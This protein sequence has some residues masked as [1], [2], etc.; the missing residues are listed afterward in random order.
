MNRAV[1]VNLSVGRGPRVRGFAVR[2][3]VRAAGDAST[4]WLPAFDPAASTGPAGLA[5]QRT[6]ATDDNS[7]MPKV[8]RFAWAV[9]A[10]N[11]AV[12]LWGAY[13]PGDGLGRGLWRPL[14]ALQRR[15]R[16]ARGGCGDLDRVLTPRDQRPGAAGGRRAP[17]RH[18]PHLPRRASGA[19]RRGDVRRADSQRG[20]DRRRAGAVPAGGRQRDDGPG[21]V[22]RGASAEHVPAARRADVD[23]LVA[24]RRLAVCDQA[25]GHGPRDHRVRGA[26]RG[27]RQRRGR[28]ARR[29]AVSGAVARRVACAPISRSRHTF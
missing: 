4:S 6:R 10:Y 28:R 3:S 1:A 14:A 5:D 27:R 12:I 16:P 23:R 11:V 19:R 9:L 22:R 17:R 25:P 29:H 7:Q 8:A 20:G 21:D 18:V 15:G 24:D 13:V 2:R 26:A